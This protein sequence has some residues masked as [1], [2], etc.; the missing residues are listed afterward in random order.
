MTW[1][2]LRKI[3]KHIRI[4]YLRISTSWSNPTIKSSAFIRLLDH[5]FDRPEAFLA[6]LASRQEPHFFFSP[7]QKTDIIHALKGKYP[8]SESRT[9]KA[10]DQ[11]CNHI[12]DLLGSGPTYLGD[13]IDWHT[14]FISGYRWDPNRFYVDNK[15]AA[16]PGGY[17]IKVPWELSRCQHFVWLG[18]AYWYSSDEK[19]SSEFVSQVEEWI[20]RN[21]P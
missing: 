4:I 15:P 10:A 16:Y 14:D 5:K 18:Q 7:E 13:K 21:P 19:Y 20:D 17:D 3:I 1:A 8:D 6:Y 12:F 11:I 2:I 9:I